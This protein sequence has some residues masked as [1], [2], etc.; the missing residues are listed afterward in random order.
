MK[1]LLKVSNRFILFFVTIVLIVIII[2]TFNKRNNV[3]FIEKGLGFIVIPIQNL[4]SEVGGWATDRIDFI[5]NIKDLEKQNKELLRKV[6][7]LT[8]EN[9]ILQQYKKKIQ[10]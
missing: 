3:S 8:Y 9:R 6:D 4:F 10:D 1:R 7:E 2:F 5:K